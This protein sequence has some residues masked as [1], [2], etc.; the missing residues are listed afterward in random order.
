MILVVFA[1]AQLSYLLV[2]SVGAPCFLSARL[3]AK[4]SALCGVRLLHHVAGVVQVFVVTALRY[5]PSD[6]LEPPCTPLELHAPTCPVSAFSFLVL[7]ASGLLLSPSAALIM[8]FG[9]NG[10]APSTAFVLQRNM[11]PANQGN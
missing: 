11:C 1:T 8:F 5:S 3:M 6:N 10:V 4:A 9:L 7:S 2:W